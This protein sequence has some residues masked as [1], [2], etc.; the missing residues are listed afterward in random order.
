MRLRPVD[1]YDLVQLCVRLVSPRAAE[2]GIVLKNRV[3]LD[4]PPVVADPQRLRQILINLLSNAVKFS[5]Q[6]GQVSV[7]VSAEPAATIIEVCDEG[8]GMEPQ[9]VEKALQP[10]VQID[11]SLSRD[12]DG[13]G[14]GL[15]LVKRF[16]DLHNGR[17]TF[18]TAPGM[19]TRVFVTL[20]Q[21][22]PEELGR[23]N[24][25]NAIWRMATARLKAAG[26]DP[27]LV[28]DGASNGRWG[29]VTPDDT[30]K[31]LVNDR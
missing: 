27:S 1:L 15:A 24:A 10:F 2:A 19:G 28:L 16:V 23:G 18:D 8:I 12:H 13:V 9:D 31:R 21:P 5:E 7:A 14:L 29:R 6:G 20:P 22:M 4:F 26:L 25:G 11:S 30:A 17:L 3:P